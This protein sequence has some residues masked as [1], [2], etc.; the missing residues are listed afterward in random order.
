ME[1]ATCECPQC[2][3]EMFDGARFCIRCGSRLDE[4]KLTAPV[5]RPA[6]ALADLFATAP[7]VMAPLPVPPVALAPP[8]PS[9]AAAPLVVPPPPPSAAIAA[10]PFVVPP[11]SAVHTM[12]ASLSEID[13][14]F[15]ELSPAQPSAAASAAAQKPPAGREEEGSVRRQSTMAD[16]SRDEVLRRA[17]LKQSLK[18]A[19]LSGIDLSGASLEGVDFS[20]A[21]LEGANFQNAKLTGA[22]LKSANLRNAKLKGAD[23][24]QADLD[25][26]DLEGAELEG[27]N[28]S[29]A[30]MKRA[31]LEGANLA[32]ANL[33]GAR[34]AGAEL[35]AA[36]LGRAL[37]KGAD[38]SYAEL[39]EAE[40]Q[41]ADL[42]GA[43][44]ANANLQGATLDGAHLPG[45]ILTDAD[46]RGASALGATFEGARLE[47]ACFDA[48][49]LSGA[50][51]RGVDA[52]HASFSGAK[53]DRAHLHGARVAGASFLN[54]ALDGVL[55]DWL[56]ASVAGNSS[57][58]LEGKR[59]TAFLA[60]QEPREESASTRYFGKGDVLRDA[61]L[62]FG[63]GSRIHIDSR[64][65]NC[66]ITLGEGAELTIGEAGVLKSCA[67]VGRGKLV[68]HGRFFERQTPGIVGVK[69]LF[70]SAEGGVVGGVEQIPEGTQ[71]AFEPG[72]RLRMKILR[73]R[74]AAAAE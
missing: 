11:P 26:A 13:A 38:L 36:T 35:A 30:N 3:A 58:R 68:V 4:P 17:R 49:A 60:G 52:R 69:S 63:E 54:A 51:L 64:F 55:F 56:D 33:T 53:L 66:S 2:H 40:L 5:T 23:L 29:G 19:G 14:S 7:P 47:R 31:A 62:E 74:T 24:S 70:V 72:S 1:I 21:D 12:A 65:E 57:L 8:P 45:A 37:L 16:H 71:F 61:T 27:A 67:I 43:N 18:R 32:G 48:V 46:L 41:E 34:M 9:A 25:K 6:A 28:L 50:V 44:L 39:T 42:S 59:A 15:G 73:P 10:P 22:N 20:R